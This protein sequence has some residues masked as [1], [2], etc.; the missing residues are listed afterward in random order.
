MEICERGQIFIETDQD[1]IFDHTKLILRGPND[2]YFYAKSNERRFP[3]LQIDPNGLES[4]KIPANIWPL[5][6]SEL[7]QAPHPLP[8]TCY[9][10]RPSLL[11]Y[12]ATS[13]SSDYALQILTEVKACEI[14]R[15]HP[16]PNIA[17]YWGCVVRDGRIRELC[18][19]RY[20]V[21]LSQMLKDGTHFNK[22][23]CLS[24]IEAGVAHMHGLGLVHN[25]LN[26]SNIMMDGDRPVIID[27]DSCKPE[28]EKLGP[29]GGSDGWAFEADY[30]RQANDLYSIE[31]IRQVLLDR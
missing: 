17:W 11:Y 28:G 1:P 16:H 9:L 20:R 4:I 14:L 24:G 21:T 7:T 25:D 31:K 27:F 5:V 12:E 26:P 6:T 19:R 22:S 3:S 2:E 29:K 10:K 18:F 30:A 15:E 23:A 8:A 13:D